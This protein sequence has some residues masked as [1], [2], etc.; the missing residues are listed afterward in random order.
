MR[1]FILFILFSSLNI[2]ALGQTTSTVSGETVLM[3]STD[4]NNPLYVWNIELTDYWSKLSDE[5]LKGYKEKNIQLTPHQMAMIFL[6]FMSDFDIGYPKG[7]A[8]PKFVVEEKIGA[9]G[10]FTNVFNALMAANGFKA[11]IINLYNYPTNELGHTVSEVYYDNKWHLYD[12]TFSAYFTDDPSNVINPNVLSFEEIKSNKP[13][14]L[15]INNQ[16]R[17]YKT[18]EIQRK[19]ASREI[20]HTANPAGPLSFENKMFFPIK[21]NPISRPKIEKKDFALK[22][23]GASFIG[24]GGANA[25]HIY[26]LESLNKNTEYRLSLIPNFI[27]GHKNLD[28]IKFKVSAS[29]CDVHNNEIEF[30][31]SHPSKSLDINFKSGGDTCDITVANQESTEFMK[32]LSLKEIKLTNVEDPSNTLN[33]GDITDSIPNQTDVNNAKFV[34]KEGVPYLDI[35]GVGEVFHPAWTGIYALQYAGME[36]YYPKKVDPNNKLFLHLVKVLEEKLKIQNGNYYWLYSFDNSYNNVTI[37]APWVSSFAQAI[38][39]EV[40]VAAYKLTKQDKYLELAKKAVKPL[41]VPLSDGGLLF[42]DGNDIWFE[43][44]PLK[45]KPTHILNAHLRSLIA[46]NELYEVTKDPIYKD[47]FDRGLITLL[48]WLP[49]FDTG[50]WLKYDLN[51]N[52]HQLFRITNPYG[53]STPEVPIESISIL[54]E[55]QK[56]LVY[57]DIGDSDDFDVSKP[58]FISGTDWLIDKTSEKLSYRSNKTS[59]PEDFNSE[60]SSDKLSSPFSFIN[61]N[62]PKSNTNKYYLKIDYLDSKK[63]NLVLQRRSISPKIKFKDVDGGIFLLTGSGL[64]RSLQVKIDQSDLGY[65]VG[66]TYSKLHYLYL[67]KLLDI[68]QDK[69][70]KSW[71]ITARAYY[72]SENFDKA[73][74]VHYPKLVLPPQTPVLPILS[75]T[76]NNVVAM[77]FGV[78]G[79]KFINGEYDFKSPVSEQSLSPYMVSLQAN[80]KFFD[81]HKHMLKTESELKSKLGKYYNKYDWISLEDQ[82][83]INKSNAL[84]WLQLNGKTYKDSISWPFDFRN[85]YNDLVQNPKWNSAFGQ[86]YVLEAFIQNNSL[87]FARKAA[88]AYKYD[89]ASNGVSSIDKSNDVWF[90]EVPNKSHILNAHLI[91]LNV[92]LGNKSVLGRDAEE[93]TKRGL[94][95][96][97]E[98]IF[99]FDNGYWSLYDQN[100]KKELMFQIDWL[101]GKTAPIIDEICLISTLSLNKTCIDVGSKKDFDGNNRINGI[102]WT[103]NQKVDGFSVRSFKN[104]HMVRSKPV[105]GGSIQNTFFWLSLPDRDFIDFWD[106]TPYIMSIKY[107]DVGIGNFVINIRSSREGNFIESLPL[108]YGNWNTKNSGEWKKYLIPIRSNDLGWF[109]GKDYHKYHLEQ[110]SEIAKKSNSVELKQVAERWQYY[111]DQYDNKSSPIFIDKRS[112]SMEINNFTLTSNLKFYQGSELKNAVD[113][114]PNSNYIAAIENQEFPHQLVIQIPE[115]RYVGTVN[116]IWESESNYASEFDVSLYE[117]EKLISTKN[118]KNDKYH[119]A[120]EIGG[121]VN[122]IVIDLKKYQGQNRLL[123]R[124][125]KVIGK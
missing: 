59:I 124:E 69:R 20:Y 119:T 93:I 14:T 48:K 28:R 22:A 108:R 118:L 78:N 120:I 83:K 31:S 73:N 97:E 65:P 94:Q 98:K 122:K 86:A 100:P 112:D 102:E 84:N 18:V 25:N 9:C 50:S 54:D 123:M 77:H 38:G 21:L 76:S 6:K 110:I 105:S 52:Y 90:E 12:T 117:D 80:G 26:K 41:T 91:S 95:S 62:F 121:V 30:I 71:A 125:L 89:I 66:N 60:L 111:L 67:N 33:Q 81:V 70:I 16:S 34:I 3:S 11:R 10:T 44:I 49:K 96:L 40:F 116:I 5:I 63:G 99:K 13:A 56:L 23:Q 43:E 68:T 115:K 19:F 113:G 32:Y 24:V 35:E 103:E 57:S 46:I 2:N 75:L 27:G 107:K 4:K 64:K 42:H 8:H 47:F 82:E 1:K 29:G 36:S 114:D 106:I 51:P 101:A 7:G 15:I 37:H 58:V 104:G 79:T 17:Y 61:I 87:D 53:F 109:M 74:L 85:A 88:N 72:N 92:L 45:E 55:N 39:V